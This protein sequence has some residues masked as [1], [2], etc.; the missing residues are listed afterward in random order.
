M[1]SRLSLN[2]IYGGSHWSKRKMQANEIHE[3][4]KLTLLTQKVEN[5]PFKEPVNIIF[6]WNSRLDLDNHGYLA[7]LII[8]GL[9]GS[10][11]HDDTKKYI[12]SITHEY[13]HGKGVKVRIQEVEKKS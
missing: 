5:S 12:H 10:L 8:D 9:K 11:I 4:V 7:K 6:N 13:W 3:M 2:G 1:S